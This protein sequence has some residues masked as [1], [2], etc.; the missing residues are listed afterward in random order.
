MIDFDYEVAKLA[1]IET[2]PKW[3]TINHD[4]F[5]YR[6]LKRRV[7]SKANGLLCAKNTMPSVGEV[8]S[9]LMTPS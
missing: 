6:I 9:A 8:I 1:I 4:D 3:E 5:C 7:F 2:T